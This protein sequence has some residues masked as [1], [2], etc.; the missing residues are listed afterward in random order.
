MS[1][2][3]LLILFFVSLFDV[4]L[5]RLGSDQ[6]Q[7]FIVSKISSLP[8]SAATLSYSSED[9]PHSAAREIHWGLLPT[10]FS[11]VC[12]FIVHRFLNIPLNTHA[13]QLAPPAILARPPPSLTL[14]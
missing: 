1:R 7:Q 6:H 5:P 3:F 10:S 2:C 13:G 4:S 14:S 9:R 11:Y 12:Q 8:A